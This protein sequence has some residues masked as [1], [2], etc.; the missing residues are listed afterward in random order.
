[1][2]DKLKASELK[3][4]NGIG[5]TILSKKLTGNLEEINLSELSN[6]IYFLSITSSNGI[7]NEKLILNKQ[8]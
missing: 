7:Y 6:G 2:N 5:E 1:M 8:K 3:I 4:V